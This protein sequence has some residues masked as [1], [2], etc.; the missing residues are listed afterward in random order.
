[1]ERNNDATEWIR[2]A[3]YRGD[4]LR[5]VPVL[6]DTLMVVRYPETPYVV[7][8]G[9]MMNQRLQVIQQVIVQVYDAKRITQEQVSGKS[10]ERFRHIID[11]H[12]SLGV[13]STLRMASNDANPLQFEPQKRPAEEDYVDTREQRRRIVPLDHEALGRRLRTTSDIFGVEAAPGVVRL[14]VDVGLFAA[15]QMQKIL[16]LGALSDG[17]VAGRRGRERDAHLARLGS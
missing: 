13:A 10:M 2:I 14:D 16:I 9:N 7:I 12:A 17:I 15:H 1:M 6:Y 11:N 8:I 5:E 3:F 4:D